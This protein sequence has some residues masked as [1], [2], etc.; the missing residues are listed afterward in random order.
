MRERIQ[1]GRRQA[2]PI[3]PCDCGLACCAGGRSGHHRPGGPRHRQVPAR[4][5]RLERQHTQPGS[6]PAPAATDDWDNVCHQ[7]TIT[8]DTTAAFRTSSPAPLTPPATRS[9]GRRSRTSNSTIFTGGG[10]R[11]RTHHRI[12][13]GRT[14]GGMPDK[15]N[16]QHSYAAR[17]SYPMSDDLPRPADQ[18]DPVRLLYSGSDRFDNSGDA[19]RV[20]GPSR[21]SHAG[22]NAAGGGTASTASTRTATCWSSANSA[23]AAPSTITSTRGIPPTASIIRIPLLRGRKPAAAETSD[24]ANCATVS[25]SGDAFC[26]IVNPARISDAVVVHGTR[27]A[28]VHPPCNGEFYE[29]G[30]NLRTL[31]LGG[32]CFSSVVSE[33]RSS[34]STTATLKDFS[35]G[36]LG[37]CTS[38]TETTPVETRR[39]SRPPGSTSR[40]PGRLHDHVTDKARSP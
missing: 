39:R 27:A 35:S 2:A 40:G 10:S 32:E 19:Q 25:R 29:G 38:K 8:D 22:R 18:R 4:R 12:G 33:T 24:D 28:P 11:T 26:G 3:R 30:I 36:Q 1:A 34:T 14:A 21:T 5:G 37:H 15:V 23:T 7:V 6:P 17:Y 9:R 13:C 20:S 16:L 31:G